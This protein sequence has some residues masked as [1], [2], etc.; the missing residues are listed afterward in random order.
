LHGFV[1]LEANEGFGLP[2]DVDET[3][4][5]LTTVLDRGPHCCEPGRSAGVAPKVAG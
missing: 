1:T 4:D 3:F 2:V 5:R